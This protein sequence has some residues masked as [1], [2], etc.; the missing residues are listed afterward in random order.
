MYPHPVLHLI[1]PAAWRDT[2]SSAPSLGLHLLILF[3]GAELETEQ[4]VILT[5]NTSST[6]TSTRPVFQMTPMVWG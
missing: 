4:R 6:E 3:G 1:V 5:E 2:L